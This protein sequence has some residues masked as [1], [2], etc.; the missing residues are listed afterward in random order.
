MLFWIE[1]KSKCFYCSKIIL[2][3]K[4]TLNIF[5]R[6]SNLSS[7]DT[8]IMFAAQ[9]VKEVNYYESITSLFQTFA[10]PLCYFVKN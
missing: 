4:N 8:N 5:S 2:K 6:P 1:G 7:L 9:K 10:F 3:V